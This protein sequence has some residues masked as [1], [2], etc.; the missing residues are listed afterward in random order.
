MTGRALAGAKVLLVG[1]FPPPF[2][3]IAVHV[4]ALREEL[5]ARGA[6]V[7]GVDVG[8]R[9]RALAGVMPAGGPGA[10]AAALARPAGAGFLIH[11][12]ISGHTPKSW[13]VALASG[14]ARRPFGPRALLTVHSG[15][16]PSFLAQG[17][18]SRALARAAV[19]AFGRVVAVTPHLAQELAVLGVPR[20]RLAVAPAFIGAAR[21]GR[22]P[23]GLAALRAERRPLL[24]CAVGPGAVYGLRV[25]FAAMPSVAR[26]RPSVGLAV[27]GPEDE[28]RACALA[29]RYGIEERVLFLGQVE[30]AQA[31][32][33]MAAS[34]LFVRP[35]LADGD[36]ISVREALSLGVPVVASAV[37][38][39]PEGVAL[40][41]NG[42]SLALAGE[43]L[44][45]LAAPR[46][47]RRAPERG[48]EPLL[49]VYREQLRA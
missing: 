20:G 36:A 24:T 19:G 39:R 32:A 23:P 31:L 9:G 30:H 44:R 13:L 37:G 29:R 6:E 46:A 43:I 48:L 45:A 28:G 41:R 33:A 42:D 26:R 38:H 22:P 27:F 15:L 8:G 5:A 47:G 7:E 14:L 25:L 10:L 11:A 35:A 12:H 49:Q 2:G 16:L 40:F 34:D 18:P 1:S 4:A 21:P 17:A 3:G